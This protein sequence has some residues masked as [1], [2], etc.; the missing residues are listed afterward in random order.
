MAVALLA[1]CLGAIAGLTAGGRTSN[2]QLLDV[3]FVALPVAWMVLSAWSRRG[4]SSLHFAAVVVSLVVLAAFLMLN[5]LRVPNLWLVAL[6]VLLNLF[7][8][9]NN[10]GMPYD[11]K[12]L[13]AAGIT[14]PTFNAQPRSTAASHP[15][16]PG[17]QLIVLGRVI[18]VRPLRTVVSFGDLFVAVGL[19]AATMSA[20]TRRREPTA[21]VRSHRRA[22]TTPVVDAA[23]ETMDASPS[24]ASLVRSQARRDVVHLL[25]D[26]H[27]LIDL[28]GDTEERFDDTDLA[29]RSFVRAALRKHDLPA[30]LLREDKLREDQLREDRVDVESAR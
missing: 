30:S 14:P 19:A 27:A 6:G 9:V 3:R 7:M 22:S 25:D 29:A 15:H 2:L 28:T 21:R 17:D 11:P 23:V 13:E 8:T 26:E 10:H 1:V 12:A 20:L 18:P 5:L 16:R 4:T 24:P